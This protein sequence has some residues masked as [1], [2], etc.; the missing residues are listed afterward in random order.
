MVTD[1]K[2]IVSNFGYDFYFD[3]TT[4]G[5]YCSFEKDQEGVYWV[6]CLLKQGSSLY[7]GSFGFMW[8]EG[9]PY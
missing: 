5:A 4:Y 6:R 3:T 9:Y 7:T 1:N 2:V 8:T